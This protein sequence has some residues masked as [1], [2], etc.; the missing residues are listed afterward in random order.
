M[1]ITE[2]DVDNVLCI[3]Y[4][5]TNP[6]FDY[7][8]FASYLRKQSLDL[9]V[10]M[11]WFM[12][13]YMPDDSVAKIVNAYIK[14]KKITTKYDKESLSAN[15]FLGCAP[16]GDKKSFKEYRAEYKDNKILKRFIVKRKAK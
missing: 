12:A 1:N 2:K 8:G 9:D 7:K 10:P 11:N 14:D 5:K 15:V 3:V 4:K 6:A 16:N 13:F